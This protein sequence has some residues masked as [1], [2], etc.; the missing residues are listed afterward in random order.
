MPSQMVTPNARLTT[1][2]NEVRNVHDSFDYVQDWANQFMKQ[3]CYD[4]AKAC[5]EFY[6]RLLD[7]LLAV[8]GDNVERK[9]NNVVRDHAFYIALKQS[10]ADAI[11]C[12]TTCDPMLCEADILNVIMLRHRMGA[13]RAV[14]DAS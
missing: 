3:R 1:L 9:L 2:I 13:E 4:Q 6:G 5:R 11:R 10:T 8:S 7:T 12:F 14:A